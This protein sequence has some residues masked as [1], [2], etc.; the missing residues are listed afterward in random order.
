VYAASHE[1]ARTV[2]DVISRRTRLAFEAQEHGVQLADEVAS[3]I[4][5]VLGWSTKDKKQSVADYEALVNRELE[6]LDQ[7]LEVNS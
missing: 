6:A 5:P 4:A 1:G 2:D 7:L 3:L